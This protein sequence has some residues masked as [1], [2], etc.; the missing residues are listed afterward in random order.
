MAAMSQGA[1]N[2]M[3]Q[4]AS[5]GVRYTLAARGG[6]ATILHLRVRSLTPEVY[7]RIERCLGGMGAVL[8]IVD[9]GSS[10]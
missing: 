4:L 10:A 5:E 8:E 6:T 1:D 2:L 9:D 3:R 7:G